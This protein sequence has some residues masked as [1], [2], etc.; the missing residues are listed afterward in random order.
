M[1]QF[2][3]VDD[4]EIDAVCTYRSLERPMAKGG[5]DLHRRFYRP[6]R[7]DLCWAT[8]GY[9]ATRPSARRF[10][11]AKKSLRMGSRRT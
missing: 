6:E 2:E 1:R 3:R 8:P 4:A 9:P 10:S 7:F 5:T 11:L